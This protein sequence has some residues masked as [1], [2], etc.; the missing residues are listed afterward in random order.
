MIDCCLSPLAR[1]GSSPSEA[2]ATASGMRQPRVSM[3]PR[4]VS[5]RTAVCQRE[6]VR[7]VFNGSD[8]RCSW[9][10]FGSA[11]LHPRP[12]PHTPSPRGAPYDRPDHALRYKDTTKTAE[13]AIG[14]EISSRSATPIPELV[15]PGKLR[16]A[17]GPAASI[18]IGLGRFRSQMRET[19]RKPP[20]FQLFRCG[21]P[22]FG[23]GRF[24]DPDFFP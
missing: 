22:V 19:D 1:Q 10:H 5:G 20:L 23:A 6:H 12:Y 18:G 9:R 16:R 3:R 17:R 8:S 11:H 24:P 15:R 4:S 7:G 21:C 2:T 14:K 13:T